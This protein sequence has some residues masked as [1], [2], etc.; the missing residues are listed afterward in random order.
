VNQSQHTKKT[1]IPVAKIMYGYGAGAAP[2][3]WA[4][5]APAGKPGVVAEEYVLFP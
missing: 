2:E 1:I 3:V 4:I 5:P